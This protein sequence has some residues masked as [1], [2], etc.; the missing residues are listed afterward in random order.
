MRSDPSI[1]G[2]ADER[3][4]L[5]RLRRRDR[6]VGSPALEG[7]LI[8]ESV[9]LAAL[10]RELNGP[11]SPVRVD[12]INCGKL[13]YQRDGHTNIFRGAREGTGDL[14]GYVLG[15]GW[16]IEIETKAKKGTIRKAQ[17][18]RQVAAARAGWIYVSVRCGDELKASVASAV[19]VVLEAIASRARVAFYRDIN[20]QNVIPIRRRAR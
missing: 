8:A 17:L 16:H 11:G 3:R 20:P 9:Y 10:E 13:A 6:P 18:A 7:A 1:K 14:V 12:R 4:L 2:S 19:A 15:H 5:D